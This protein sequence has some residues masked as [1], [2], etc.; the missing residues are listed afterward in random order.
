MCTSE[1]YKKMIKLH[2][3]SMIVFLS[4]QLKRQ[5][6]ELKRQ[7]QALMLNLKLQPISID[8]NES[9]ASAD[10][11]EDDRDLLNRKIKGLHK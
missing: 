6:K 11:S 7:S 1:H 9:V 4:K 5:N 2:V 3:Y 8:F 10:E